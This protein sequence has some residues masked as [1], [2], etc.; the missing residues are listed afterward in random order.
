MRLLCCLCN[1][2][3]KK[4]RPTAAFRAPRPFPRLP[5][6]LVEKGRENLESSGV[7]D[8]GMKILVARVAVAATLATANVISSSG[9]GSG[10]GNG[11]GCGGDGGG[12]G[13]DGGGCRG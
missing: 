12:C 1:N 11:G 3:R 2:G 5:P 8:G 7:K 9:G 10:C 4:K 13:G 6:E